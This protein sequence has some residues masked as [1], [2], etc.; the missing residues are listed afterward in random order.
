[1]PHKQG[2]TLP[3]PNMFENVHEN[4][5]C[6]RP[7]RKFQKLSKS[8]NHTVFSNHSMIKIWITNQVR[9]WRI[10]RKHKNRNHMSELTDTA[11]TRVR[12]QQYIKCQKRNK[13][14][15]RKQKRRK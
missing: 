7:Q 12:G 8:K 3:F 13:M 10:S 1:M 4:W 5:L 14:N 11:K 9:K 6:K 15:E 2:G